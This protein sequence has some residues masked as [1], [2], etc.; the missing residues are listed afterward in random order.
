M[1]PL[2][3]NGAW[4]VLLP[5][6]GRLPRVGQVVVAEHPGRAGFE[7][8]KRVSAV[9]EHRGLVWLAGDNREQSTDSEQFGPISRRLVVGPVI[10]VVRPGRPKVVRINAQKLW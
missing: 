3:P 10:A 9:S 8:V 7:M 1:E 4:A 5:R 6:P 2:L